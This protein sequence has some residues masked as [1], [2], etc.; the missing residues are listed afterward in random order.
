MSGPFLTNFT[1]FYGCGCRIPKRFVMPITAATV[2]AGSMR[3]ISRIERTRISWAV[4]CSATNSV[5][6][7]KGALL[8]FVAT[9][10][11]AARPLAL[12]A[13]TPLLEPNTTIPLDDARPDGISPSHVFAKI[14]L[15]D[16][17]LQHILDARNVPVPVYPHEIETGILPMHV[18]RTVLTC[19]WRLQEF[20]DNVGVLA[21]PTVSGAP[22]EYH[23]R[24]VFFIVT[25]MLD[26]VQQI[27]EHEKISDLPNDETAQ[28]GKTPTDVFHQAVRV[29]A[30]LNALC[31]YRDLK[32]SEV[33]A[34]MVC[35]V[36]DVKSILRQADPACRYRIDAPPSKQGLE[37][38]DVFEV[39][40]EIRGLI[41]EKRQSLGMAVVPVPS[42][43][44]HT[45]IFPRDVFF[46]TQIIIAELNLLKR[47]LKTI[48]STPLPIPVEHK[49][50]SDVH[51]QALMARYLLEQVKIKQPD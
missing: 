45:K 2:L 8:L 34:Q 1:Q 36:E 3:R 28:T 50:P 13:Q 49:V 39:C 46:Q 10:G 48:S 14:E 16:R 19:T 31:N 47:P 35:A 41:N 11:M 25:M 15:L 42:S 43:P 24:D 6:L 33:Y 17:Q 23:P 4:G 29:F 7:L 30:K 12:S 18:Y 5:S 9:T 44:E 51:R 21:V 37:P 22:R 32:P 20:D 26:N 40:L 27:A 38:A